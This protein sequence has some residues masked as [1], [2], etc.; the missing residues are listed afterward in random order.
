VG[1][2]GG[3]PYCL[4]LK[5]D[6]MRRL[7]KVLLLVALVPT[8]SAMIGGIT[9]AKFMSWADRDTSEFSTD[10]TPVSDEKNPEWYEELWIH[11][12]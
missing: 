5:G 7:L 8:V 3:N 2:C 10:G 11:N 4:T 6:L 9:V 1:Y 12:I